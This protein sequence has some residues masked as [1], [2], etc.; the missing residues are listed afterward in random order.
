MI[1]LKTKSHFFRKPYLNEIPKIQNKLF[2][3]YAPRKLSKLNV[4][5]KFDQ[6][7]TTF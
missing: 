1:F 4:K 5:A 3:K 6:I 2:W 7:V